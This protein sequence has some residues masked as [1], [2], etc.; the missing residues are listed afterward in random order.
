VKVYIMSGLAM[1]TALTEI[2]NNTPV[3]YGGF[4]VG[5]PT[6]HAPYNFAHLNMEPEF[7]GCRP[8]LR[9]GEFLFLTSS[10]I[11]E[12]RG[13]R[14]VIEAFLLLMEER[15]LMLDALYNRLLTQGFDAVVVPTTG[16][17]PAGLKGPWVRASTHVVQLGDS[18][19]LEPHSWCNL[20]A[21]QLR[22]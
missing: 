10:G 8:G 3:T 4:R 2:V 16:E 19:I 20:P 7:V 13:K 11:E 9:A 18:F 12:P 14:Q 17:N 15:A 1:A 22:E 5:D 6:G 21:E